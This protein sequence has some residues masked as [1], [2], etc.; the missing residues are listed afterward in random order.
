MYVTLFLLFEANNSNNG[1]AGGIKVIF[2]KKNFYIKKQSFLLRKKFKK[3]WRKGFAVSDY[4]VWARQFSIFHLSSGKAYWRKSFYMQFIFPIN[5]LS[6]LIREPPWG[7]F[8]RDFGA[9]VLG[10]ILAPTLA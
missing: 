4:A 2:L 3:W 6:P 5:L 7:G 1:I 8:N 10:W 9:R